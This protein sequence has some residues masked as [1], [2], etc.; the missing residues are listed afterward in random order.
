MFLERKFSYSIVHKIMICKIV[1][2][3]LS[4]YKYCASVVNILKNT[5]TD[6][7]EDTD[8]IL[9][10]IGNLLILVSIK[11]ISSVYYR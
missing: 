9:Y 3:S 5:V 11:E 1:T 8:Y 7:R 2:R 6:R 4:L 10:V